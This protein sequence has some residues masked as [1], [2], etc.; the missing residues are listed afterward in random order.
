MPELALAE[1]TGGV[2]EL[3]R[4]QEV[5]RLLEVGSDGEDL[6][7]EVLH[8]HDAVFAEM[9]LDDGV[10]GERNALL[11]VGLGVAT[12]VDELTDRLEVGIAVGD[13]GFDDL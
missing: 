12:L 2:V 10:V 5:A 11:A 13:E 3:E 7:D 1:A 4:P 6:V 8:A 9:L